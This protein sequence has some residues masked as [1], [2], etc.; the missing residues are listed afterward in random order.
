MIAGGFRRDL[1]ACKVFR[2]LQ[3]GFRKRLCPAPTI[4]NDCFGV[5]LALYQHRTVETNREAD[6]EILFWR[7]F[8]LW[9]QVLELIT[10]FLRSLSRLHHL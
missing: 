3:E 1:M 7:L 10:L 8:P 6:R 2:G 9:C 4:C 5:I